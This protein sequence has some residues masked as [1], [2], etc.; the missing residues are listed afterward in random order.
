[1]KLCECGREGADTFKKIVAV[2]SDVPKLLAYF[3]VNYLDNLKYEDGLK[4]LKARMQ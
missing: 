4:Y 1:M 3:K 2:C